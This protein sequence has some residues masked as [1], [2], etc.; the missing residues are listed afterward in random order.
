[1]TS[2]EKDIRRL[3]LLGIFHYVL[4]GCISLGAYFLSSYLIT[5]IVRIG[6]WAR[7]EKLR[8]FERELTVTTAIL[9]LLSWGLVICLLISG[10][11]LRQCK[12]R[13]FSTVVAGIM[14]VVSLV[15]IAIMF[16]FPIFDNPIVVSLIFVPFLGLGTS[17]LITLN[18]KSIKEL[19]QNNLQHL[20]NLRTN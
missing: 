6:T 11:E 7:W 8:T 1:M 14:C 9:A 20:R 10:Q 12:G 13:I 4:G 3:H 5:Y 19:Y 16:R 2:E 18:K 17:T 15:G